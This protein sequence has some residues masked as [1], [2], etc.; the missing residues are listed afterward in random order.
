MKPT[1]GQIALLKKLNIEVNDKTEIL[2]EVGNDNGETFKGEF[3]VKTKR[4]K[5]KIENEMLI[6]TF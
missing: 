5:Y 2:A 6:K 1:K 4:K 3:I